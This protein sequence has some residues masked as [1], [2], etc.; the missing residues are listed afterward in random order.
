M[1]GFNGWDKIPISEF[2]CSCVSRHKLLIWNG[3]FSISDIAD[4]SHIRLIVCPS[5]L[6]D[7]SPWAS[8]RNLVCSMLSLAHFWMHCKWYIHEHLTQLHTGCVLFTD[9]MH[10]KHETA[11][12]WQTSRSSFEILPASSVVPVMFH[13]ID[14]KSQQTLFIEPLFRKAWNRAERS[15]YA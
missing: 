10:I 3:N 9:E 6:R 15:R 7:D 11:P 5:S 4:Q 12:L 1:Q 14:D 2:L 8:R 13:V